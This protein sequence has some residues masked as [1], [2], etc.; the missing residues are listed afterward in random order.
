MNL[1]SHSVLHGRKNRY[2]SELV[3]NGD[4][5][6]SDLSGYAYN[7]ATGTRLNNELLVTRTAPDS[8]Y[9]VYVAVNIVINK[10]YKIEFDVISQTGH[11]G[12]DVFSGVAVQSIGSVGSI[13][14]HFVAEFTANSSQTVLYIRRSGAGTV[15][16]TFTL[17]NISLRE[18]LF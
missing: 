16:E 8:Q 15:G 2:G 3:V 7:R 9:G 17:D 5:S 1:L 18:V 14:A 6:S 10:R 11:T 12:L 13:P 4:L